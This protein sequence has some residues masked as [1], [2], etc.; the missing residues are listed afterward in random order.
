MT[1]LLA[2]SMANIFVG[3]T[4]LIGTILTSLF[5]LTGNMTGRQFIAMVFLLDVFVWLSVF[6]SIKP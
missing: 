5:G 1:L 4:N 3:I 2:I 6:L